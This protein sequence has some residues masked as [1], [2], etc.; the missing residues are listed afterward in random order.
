MQ[1]F[2]I[3]KQVSEDILNGTVPAPKKP[4]SRQRETITQ[5]FKNNFDAAE[6]DEDDDDDIGFGPPKTE[7][8]KSAPNRKAEAVA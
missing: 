6:D 2:T 7:Q 5:D 4:Q 8:P 1:N 3:V